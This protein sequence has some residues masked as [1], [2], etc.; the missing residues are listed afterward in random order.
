MRHL[1]KFS[2]LCF[3]MLG[4][5]SAAHAA[6]VTQFLTATIS[7]TDG[8]NVDTY[9]LFGPKGA[10]LSGKRM[11]IRFQYQ[12]DDFIKSCGPGPGLSQ[13]TGSANSRHF[14]QVG[15]S[16]YIS[17][18]VP[19]GL[20][21]KAISQSVLIFVDIDGV[22]AS[23]A[24][25]SSGNVLIQNGSQSSQLQVDVDEPPTVG[26]P[27]CT[28]IV[29]Y[30]KPINFTGPLSAIS[31]FPALNTVDFLYVVAPLRAADGSLELEEF[32]FTVQGASP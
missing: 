27:A 13:L 30:Q 1:L 15:C 17:K 29:G 6:L 23:F 11:N 25:A 19:D 21:N 31:N 8:T 22:I 24:P 9:G 4:G 12:T 14:A 2:A 32:N 18:G 28:L 7:T 10:S 20:G 5:A 16:N 26:D 3:C